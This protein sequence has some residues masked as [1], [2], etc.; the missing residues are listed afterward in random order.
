MSQ[1]SAISQR[2]W[3]AKYRF[4]TDAGDPVDKTVED[5]WHRVAATL[6]KPE[7]EQASWAGRFA[8]A[9]A[10]FRFIPAGRILAGAGTDRRVT[11]FNCFV[12]G[13]IPDDMGGIFENLKEAALTLQ[14][15]GGIGYDFST[16]RPKGAMVHGVGADASG[17]LSFMHVWDAMCRTIMSAG[18]RRG[19]MMGTLRC[20]HPDIEDFIAAKENPERLRMFNLSVL[21]T[22]AFMQ[23]VK[24]DAPWELSFGGA[25]Y[26]VVPAREL[27]DRIMRATYAYAE[28]GVIFIDRINQRNNLHYCEEIQATN[29]CGEQPLPPYGACLLGSINLAKLVERPFEADARLDL[30]ALEALAPVAVRMLDNAID[31]SRFPLPAQ[32]HEA[33]AKRRIGLGITGLADALIMCGV[34]Y[35][36][37]EAVELTETWMRSLQHAAYGASI[38]LAREKGAFPLFD[39]DAY[40]EGE[41]VKGLDRELRDAIAEHG[42]RNAL[43][44]SVA[45]TGTISLFADNVS[46][47]LEPVFAFTAQRAILQPD[48]SREFEEVSDYAYRLFRRVKG[49]E[50]DLTPAFVDTQSLEPSAHVVMQAAVQKFVDSSVSKTIN[51]PEDITFEAFRDVYLQAYDLGCKGCTTYRPNPVTGAVLEARSQV[52]E[53]APLEPQAKVASAAPVAPPHEEEVPEAP[54]PP[55]R[56][57]AEAS[58]EHDDAGGPG[59]I[60]YMT[61]PLARP[62]ALPG[63]TYK[64]RWPESDHAIYIT[65]NDVVQDGRRR[66]FEIF[67]NSKNMEHYAWTLA[68][69]RMISAVFRRGGDVSFVVEEL[70]AVF[71]PRGGAWLGGRYVP[72]LLAA[73]GDVIERHMI[74]IGFLPAD[75]DRLQAEPRRAVAGEP[76]PSPG[77]PSHGALRQC[78]KCGGAA[79][80]HQEGC[81]LCM[82][83]GYSRCS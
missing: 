52:P 58:V 13:R 75:E 74:D 53:T 5:S 66:P 81:D 61:Q 71:D 49:E 33:L 51:L 36:S 1:I 11:L 10:D 43:V 7:R 67:I 37:A 48:G 24:E 76:D 47:G 63:R 38:D 59:G 6:A 83:C 26:R 27:F 19:A 65:L 73:I 16:L 70:K 22:D 56:A 62:E 17:P 72:S 9:L 39:R 41:S 31:I 20:D 82:A 42:I 30:A 40:L 3:D 21:V 50:A 60:V 35:G 34:R 64:L 4:K 18:S 32:K 80:I 44:T 69:T 15:G 68:L 28:P 29:P 46:S 57:D 2:I 14:Q 55:L 79:L 23:A 78:P 54:P 8:E 25:T 12:M 77:H 45:P